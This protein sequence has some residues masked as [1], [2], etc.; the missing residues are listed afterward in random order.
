M[1]G[2]FVA[3][4]FEEG[5]KTVEWSALGPY[6]QLVLKCT[7]SQGHGRT[8]DFRCPVLEPRLF[9]V[10][11]GRYRLLPKGKIQGGV[12]QELRLLPGF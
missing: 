4:S 11:H 6:G 2:N 9:A 12:L 5:E 10:Y 8:C 1:I 3:W 7:G